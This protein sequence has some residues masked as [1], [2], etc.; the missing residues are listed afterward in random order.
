MTIEKQRQPSFAG[1]SGAVSPI[2]WDVELRGH[3]GWL[4][5]ILAARLG[6]DEV[7]EVLQEVALAA[8][9]AKSP[10][11]APAKIGPW[12]YRIAIRQALLF[13]RR[14]GR[15]RKVIDR[16]VQQ[17]ATSAVVADGPMRWLLAEERQ[18]TVR[19]AMNNLPRRDREILLLKY[20]QDWTYQQMSDHL[21]ISQSAI[22]ARLHRARKRLRSELEKQL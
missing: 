18:A 16:V 17:G 10:P 19:R 12:L 21:G 13:R 3:L 20:D 1:I 14:A 4:R 22:E 2:D 15:R 11:E 5:S 7:D 6:A 8:V 9:A